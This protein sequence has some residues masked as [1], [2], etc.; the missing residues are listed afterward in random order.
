[1]GKKISKHQ[2]LKQLLEIDLGR[3]LLLTAATS[4]AH[5]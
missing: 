1:M 3:S 5:A 4:F 2:R